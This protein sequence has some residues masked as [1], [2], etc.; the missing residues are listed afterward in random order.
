MKIKKAIYT[1]LLLSVFIGCEKNTYIYITE[2]KKEEEKNTNEDNK[3][4]YDIIYDEIFYSYLLEQF[5]IDKDGKISSDEA[6]VVKEIDYNAENKGLKSLK[7]LE[8]LPN[9]EKLCLHSFYSVDTLHLTKNTKLEILNIAG[10]DADFSL[11]ENTEL[12]ELYLT[13]CNNI[14]T[15]NL[16][17][18][19][20]LKILDCSTS[21]IESLNIQRNTELTKLYITALKFED[22][23]LSNNTKLQILNCSNNLKLKSLNLQH[24]T[25]LT[26]LSIRGLALQE[27]YL[28]D[29]PELLKVDATYCNRTTL[30]LST[31]PKLK[32][33]LLDDPTSV[34][35]TLNLDIS[36]TAVEE[37]RTSG[38]VHSIKA[39]GCKS[40]KYL[41]S[42]SFVEF[43]DLSESSLEEIS[44]GP[45]PLEYNTW[46]RGEEF[47][48]E[49]FHFANP[50]TPSSAT[51]LLNDCPNLKEFYYYQTISG[52]GKVP[53]HMGRV[54]ID[55]SNCKSLT[56]FFAN[57][58]AELKIDNCPAL[59][60]FTCKGSYTLP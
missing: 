59:I 32:T 12:K 20:K 49:K 55:I 7:D 33:V 26:E 56:K 50:T 46:S 24:N 13:G 43:I 10:T 51:L 14:K 29:K 54:T 17:N 2:E 37:I 30:N 8:K 58:V 48:P 1:L 35:P 22:V 16:S 11:S 47:N 52:S 42:S 15:L 18:S 57:H 3:N 27:F 19:P 34:G 39:R 9:L 25:K 44:Y 28:G 53:D 5:D 60:E 21:G 4:P 45:V 31:A 38:N 41:S 36:N 40:L 23:D 6:S